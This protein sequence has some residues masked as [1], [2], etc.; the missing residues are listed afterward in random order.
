MVILENIL[1]IR[2]GSNV[3]VN[4]KKLR[5][6]GGQLAPISEKK[7]ATLRQVYHRA[8]RSLEVLETE[9]VEIE[10][11]PAPREQGD[12]PLMMAIGPAMTMAIPML[13]SSGIAIIGARSSGAHA[14]TFMYTGIITSLCSALIGVGW[15]LNNIR[16][17]KDKAKKEEIR[18]QY[19][20]HA[21]DVSFRRGL[22]LQENAGFQ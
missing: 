14:S 11:P 17:G 3:K 21:A 10:A 19:P 15:A 1:A 7:Q 22:Q 18:E 12:M 8:P 2:Q 20:K 9:P 5:L 13:M 16:Y 6:W 4:N